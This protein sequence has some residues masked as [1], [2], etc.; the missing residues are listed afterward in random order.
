MEGTRES[1]RSKTIEFLTCCFA[2]YIHNFI[3]EEVCIAGLLLSTYDVISK[4]A[5]FLLRHQ[6]VY[7]IET[8]SY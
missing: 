6:C 3:D 5:R 2:L 8:T 4:I 7:H 1:F